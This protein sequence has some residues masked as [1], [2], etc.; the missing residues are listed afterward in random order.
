MQVVAAQD[1]TD[2]NVRC[3]ISSN[4]AQNLIKVTTVW[5]K[6]FWL[7]TREALF[8]YSVKICHA[9]FLKSP[10]KPNFVVMSGFLRTPPFA[11]ATVE[12][13]NALLL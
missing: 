7:V 2:M 4:F 1:R 3:W 13:Y 12:C 11:V 6:M 10:E 8:E 5:L 9:G